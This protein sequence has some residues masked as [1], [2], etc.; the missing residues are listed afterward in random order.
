MFY[1]HFLLTLVK[2][3][4]HLWLNM[5]SQWNFCTQLVLEEEIDLIAF[6]ASAFGHNA[7]NGPIGD[8]IFLTDILVKGIYDTNN[9]NIVHVVVL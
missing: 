5:T 2:K 6:I 9:L 8:S 1:Y 3:S 4:F 7:L